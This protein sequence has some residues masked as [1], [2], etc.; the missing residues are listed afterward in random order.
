MKIE[1]GDFE[2]KKSMSSKKMKIGRK[3][4]CERKKSVVHS[5]SVETRIRFRRICRSSKWLNPK[6]TTKQLPAQAR[7]TVNDHQMEIGCLF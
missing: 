4:K 1:K 6:I 2:E 3:E 7:P 5:H